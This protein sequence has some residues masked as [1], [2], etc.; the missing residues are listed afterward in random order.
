MALHQ[1]ED[2]ARDLVGQRDSRQLELIFDGLARQQPISPHAERVI[3]PRAMA[4]RRAGAHDEQFAQVTIAHLGDAP[5]PLFAAGRILARR[6]PEGGS[7]LPA[8]GESTRLPHGGDDR[9]RGDRANTGNCHQPPCGLVNLDQ[10][11][12]LFVDRRDLRVDC[13][14]LMTSGARARRT[15]S[16][17]MTSPLSSQPSARRRLSA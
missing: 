3:V 16:G 12:D 10:P 6:Q 4:K 5:E 13:L 14:D 2:D 11:L 1:R 9:L 17:T 7:E 15:Q 8:T